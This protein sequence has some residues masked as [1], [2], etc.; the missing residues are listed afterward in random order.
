[1]ARISARWAM[2]GVAT[3]TVLI[4]ACGQ[5]PQTGGVDP[6][7]VPAA[8]NTPEVVPAAEPPPAPEPAPVE[9][10]AAVLPEQT[11]SPQP[12]ASS[13][14]V[15][16]SQPTVSKKPSQKPSAKSSTT[17]AAK[18]TAKP[19][20]KAGPPI[21]RSGQNSDRVKELQAR[22]AQIGWFS[23][24]V[25]GY[26]G[27]QTS[28]AVAGF[29]SKRGLPANGTVDQTTWNKLV[30][31]TR[32]PTAAELSNAPK[33]AATKSAT[34][35]PKA[36]NVDSRCLT[37][38]VICISKRTNTLRWMQNG[39]VL[40][41]MDVRFGTSEY[42]TREGTFAVQWK[43][44]DHVSTIY[45]TPMPYALFFSGGQA[46][47]YS[48]DF[49]ARGYNGGS[50]GC[51]NLRNKSGAQSLFNQARAGDKVVVYR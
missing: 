45:H 37:G 28:A 13:K 33:P 31:M 22:L 10:Q 36:A 46:V 1:M 39:N 48:P 43:S 4:T 12:T 7:A 16:S 23:G 17:S 40:M 9:T 30:G 19:A 15:V 8:V 14:P 50:H 44:R 32:K 49:A 26:Y 3:S 5:M 25:T 24:S 47:H 11:P 34:Q 6:A 38:R 27:S 29:Q 21:L 18:T 41:T 2:V 20:P 51:V 35:A 42:P